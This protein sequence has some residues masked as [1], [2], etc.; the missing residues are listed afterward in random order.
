M[1]RNIIIRNYSTKPGAF[2]RSCIKECSWIIQELITLLNRVNNIFESLGFVSTNGGKVDIN[3]TSLWV[4]GKL[5]SYLDDIAVNL[6]AS[7]NINLNYN[8]SGRY[9]VTLFKYLT[10]LPSQ[11]KYI[12]N[13]YFL[14]SWRMD[15]LK[16]F[17]FNWCTVIYS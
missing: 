6:R 16:S 7:L 9:M 5:W 17:Y 14:N 3:I 11:Y 1:D 2:I 13:V 8:E 4:S 12:N 15:G 10:I